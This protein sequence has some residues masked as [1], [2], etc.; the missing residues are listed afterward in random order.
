MDKASKTPL[1]PTSNPPPDHPPHPPP[2]HKKPSHCAIFLVLLLAALWIL[3]KHV[4]PHFRNGHPQSHHIW[5]TNG[6]FAEDTIPTAVHLHYDGAVDEG[7]VSL[8]FH[9]YVRHSEPKEED[10]IPVVYAKKGED[11]RGKKHRHYRH[12]HRKI[13]RDD[14]E[15]GGDDDD[16]DD[17]DDGDDDE[18]GHKKKWFTRCAPVSAVD[19]VATFGKECF[20]VQG[21]FAEA[22]K[23]TTITYALIGVGKKKEVGEED[24]DELEGVKKWWKDAKTWVNRGRRYYVLTKIRVH[25]HF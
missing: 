13:R 21:D 5:V 19:G 24:G 9:K 8:W 7:G 10:V 22:E 11:A 12:G 25:K 15:E 18:G 1:L 17:D 20:D 2:P 16:D 6:T 23:G 3:V 14:D 4:C